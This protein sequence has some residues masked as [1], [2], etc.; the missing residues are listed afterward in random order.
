[1]N[2]LEYVPAI[3]PTIIGIEK[4]KIELTPKMYATIVTI[5]I[6]EIVVIEV[7][8]ERLKDCEVLILTSSATDAFF[9]RALFSLILS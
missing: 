2:K 8:I 1:M 9:I 5:I 6:V 7:L 4:L 3:I